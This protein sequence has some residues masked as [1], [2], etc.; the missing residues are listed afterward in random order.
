VEIAATLEG[1]GHETWAVG[2]ALR[3]LLLHDDQSD[4]DLATAATPDVVQRLFPHTVA[5]G[6]RYGTVGVLDR[7]HRLH[8]VTTFR[9]DVETDGRHAVVAFGVSLEDDLARRDFTINAMAY[10]PLRHQWSDPFRGRDDLL[11]GIV[12]AVGRAEDRFREDYLRILRG[13]RFAARFGF[14]I[15]PET[16]RAAV[17]SA[18]GL[19]DLSAERVRD[20]WFKSL[21]TAKSLVVLCR[22][23]REAGAAAVLLPELEAEVP[24]VSPPERDPIVLTAL[25]CRDPAGVLGRLRASNQ[26]I[27]RAA[28]LAR[29]PREPADGSD[30]AVRRWLAAVGPAAPDLMRLE[31][32]R[33][34]A[35]PRWMATADAVRERRDPITR[36]DLAVNGSDLIGL[37][38]PAGPEL[39]R[40]LDRLLDLVLDD[41]GA[42]TRTRLLEMVQTWK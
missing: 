26:E 7:H 23:W 24:E 8:E 17:D 4:V 15:E 9:R 2:G 13:V 3:D 29:G 21:R 14:S 18:P 38:V 27:G 12:R 30:R 6:T 36:G 39:G 31:Q 32:Y 20:E 41:P 25:L 37:G 28:A 33:R 35:R 22:L 40:L 19:R 16:W 34:D 42:N 11:A 10:H 1:A 5:V